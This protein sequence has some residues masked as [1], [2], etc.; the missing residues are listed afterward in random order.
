MPVMERDMPK[1][2]DDFV[3]MCSDGY[4]LGFN[5]ANGGN[6]SYRMTEEETDICK[7][8][9]GFDRKSPLVKMNTEVKALA[10]EYFITTG[11]GR[12]MRNVELDPEGSLGIVQID[13][14]GSSYRILWGL[15]DAGPTSEFETHLL[16]HCVRKEAS[17]G[18]DRVMYH[19]HPESLI[20]MTYISPL[21]DEFFSRAIWRSMTEAVMV[22]PEGIGVLKWLVPGSS[23]L[24]RMTCKKLEDYRAVVWA[25]HGLFVTGSSFDDAF[26]RAHTIEKSASIYMKI[27][28]SGR[29]ILQDISDDSLKKICD[30]LGL[31]INEELLNG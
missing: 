19:L 24:A 4:R 30:K 9:L 25:H 14:A 22:I 7:N 29:E 6:A 26:G 12:L 31:K 28:S 27:L 8:E 23:D 13:E 18:Q 10:G 21:E 3:R 2:I 17:H 15:K 1:V 5:E 20:A 16:S 11:A